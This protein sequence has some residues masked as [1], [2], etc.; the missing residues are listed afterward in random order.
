MKK[1]IIKF[2]NE[3]IDNKLLIPTCNIDL[4]ID[5]DDISYDLIDSLK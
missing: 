1:E 5:I 4:S 3:V 2:A